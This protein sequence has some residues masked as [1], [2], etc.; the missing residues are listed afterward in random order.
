MISE[1]S[2]SFFFVERPRSDAVLGRFKYAVAAVLASAHDEVCGHITC[3]V[4]TFSDKHAASGIGIAVQVFVDSAFRISIPTRLFTV[5]FTVLLILLIKTP[6][7]AQ[8][9][10]IPIPPVP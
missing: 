4:R 8:G 6:V 1:G 7:Q 3:V 10:A 5:C 2:V 9:A